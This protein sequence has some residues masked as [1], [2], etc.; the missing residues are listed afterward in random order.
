[1]PRRQH[2]KLRTLWTEY[3]DYTPI[4]NLDTRP[5]FDEVLVKDEHSV[6]GQIIRENWD[7]IHPL[8]R[9]YMLS[10]AFE[11]RA[12]LNE[13]NKVKSNLDLK[14]ENLD[15]H[16][17]VFDQKAQR[18]LL[19]KE[20]EKEHIKEEIEEKYKNLLE[21]KDQ[22][23]AQYKLLADSVK[24]GF[25]DSTTSTQDT[26]GTDMSDKDQRITDLELLVQELKDQ[27][28]SQE[29]ES[30]NIQTGISKNFQQQING[31]TSEL[32]EKQEQVDKLRDVLRKAKEQLVSLK[33]KTGELTERNVNL[34][35]MVK[36]RDDK[37]RKVIRTIE[38]LD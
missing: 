11:W 23:I 18:L 3:P 8:A 20:A 24:T 21:Q 34:E 12:I 32:Y 28:K 22:E 19:E 36:D 2:K 33:E 26:I 30:M 4:H 1:M 35:D 25:D 10:S 38:S 5:L 16:Q 27:V 7:L 17:D 6:L 37:L 31:I 15:S 29:L 14:Q 9:D 13:L